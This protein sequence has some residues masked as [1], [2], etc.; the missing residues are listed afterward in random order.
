[1][2]SYDL[3]GK[4][5]GRLYVVK[6]APKRTS[7]VRWLVR[8]DCGNTREVITASLV[9]G[10]TQSCGCLWK[11]KTR[12]VNKKRMTKHGA[13]R[14]ISYS[15]YRSMLHRCYD[16]ES[17][18]YANYGARGIKVCNR[19][20]NT[21][22]GYENFIKDMGERPSKAYSIDRKDTDG[23]YTKSN[24]QWS[25]KRKQANNRR[26]NHIVSYKNKEM[27]LAQAIRKSKTTI[28]YLRVLARIRSGW[29]LNE[30]LF[31]PL[32]A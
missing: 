31:T 21:K 17:I 26:T 13:S 12:E 27:T 20:K 19:W 32:P 15:S 1:M 6:K 11:E 4:Q 16:P 29:S 9:S 23:D 7:G 24:C 22:T 28:P 10:H 2:V 18:S 14:S 5:F 3:K 8:C 25:T 30:A